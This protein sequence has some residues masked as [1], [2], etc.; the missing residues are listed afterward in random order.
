[1][2]SVQEGF[3]ARKKMIWMLAAS[4]G[5]LFVLLLLSFLLSD[6]NLRLGAGGKTGLQVSVT[7][8]EPIGW[9]ETCSHGRSKAC[10][11]R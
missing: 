7:C 2:Q 1:M 4:I 5:F 9:E 10:V 8:L 11:C 3:N 6:D